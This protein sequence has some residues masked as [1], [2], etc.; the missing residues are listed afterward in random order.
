MKYPSFEN[1]AEFVRDSVR[2]KR[3]NRIDPDTQLVPDLAITERNGIDLLRG[4]EKHYGI[5]FTS[6]FY[7]RIRS[8]CLIH[9]KN[10][11]EPPMIQPL[12]TT[13]LSHGL[14]FTVGQLYKAVL[15]GLSKRPETSPKN[16]T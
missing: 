6:E 15:Q 8:E 14:S 10:E 12:F 3:T 1:L 5:E 13:S 4:I 2:S 11:D 7:D 9:S 16:S